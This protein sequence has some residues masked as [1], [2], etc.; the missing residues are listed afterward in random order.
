[1]IWG[2][3]STGVPIPWFWANNSSKNSNTWACI[4]LAHYTWIKKRPVPKTTQRRMAAV[5]ELEAFLRPQTKKIIDFQYGRLN[6]KQEYLKENQMEGMNL[7]VKNSLPNSGGPIVEET[8]QC[9]KIYIYSWKK[10]GSIYGTN[11]FTK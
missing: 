10:R 5:K 6:T 3:G 7:M 2:Q 8:P 1:M 4:Y 11:L 9:L